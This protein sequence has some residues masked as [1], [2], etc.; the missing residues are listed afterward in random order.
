M[1]YFVADEKVEVVKC[2]IYRSDI[3]ITI[4]CVSDVLKTCK[5]IGTNVDTWTRMLVAIYFC[6]GGQ[7]IGCLEVWLSL[8]C[9]IGV[10]FR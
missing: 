4:S 8:T 3:Y 7:K 9:S 2:F 10:R 6:E 1:P 5:G